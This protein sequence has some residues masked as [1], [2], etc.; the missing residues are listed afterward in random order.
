MNKKKIAGT[1]QELRIKQERSDVR[2]SL[3]LCAAVVIA[4]NLIC[5][6]LLTPFYRFLGDCA[7]SLSVDIER[8]GGVVQ[9]MCEA[10]ANVFFYLSSFLGTV[11]FFVGAA[12]VARFAKIKKVSKSI[13]ASFILMLGMSVPTITTLVVFAVKKMNEAADEHV[14][15]AD[16]SAIISEVVFLLIRVAAVAAISLLLSCK[17]PRAGSRLYALL[18]AGFMFL[19]AVGLEMYDTTVPFFSSGNITAVDVVFAVLSYLLY[20]IHALVGYIVMCK[21]F[22]GRK[23]SVKHT[24]AP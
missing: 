10:G 19:C 2:N 21:F 24:P 7:Y 22:D 13:A 6:F 11:A 20:A 4:I 16:V 15:I 14:Y 5:Q 17:V 9:V 8:S 12:F 18:C 3:L 1:R 23:R